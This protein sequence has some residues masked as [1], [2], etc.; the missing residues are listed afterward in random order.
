[1]DFV[2]ITEQLI[3]LSAAK[4][5]LN[6][7]WTYYHELYGPLNEPDNKYDFIKFIGLPSKKMS[8]MISRILQE[9]LAFNMTSLIKDIFNMVETADDNEL[10]KL[11]NES[12]LRLHDGD[13]KKQILEYTFIRLI[14]K[15]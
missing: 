4:N 3:L 1:M 6:K 5:D 8:I 12:M 7:I 9:K 13:I 14:E 15:F 10:L 2:T 11:A